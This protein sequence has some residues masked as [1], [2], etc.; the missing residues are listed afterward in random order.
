MFVCKRESGGE[1]AGTRLC[2]GVGECVR[3]CVRMCVC[4]RGRER[5]R[6]EKEKQR[7]RQRDRKV[8][9]MFELIS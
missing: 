1:R 9:I 4:E 3:G 5:E 7:Q 6:E 8:I 2:G